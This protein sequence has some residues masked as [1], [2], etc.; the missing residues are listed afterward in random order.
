MMV[1]IL[2]PMLL[3]KRALIAL[4]LSLCLGAGV[5]RAEQGGS[6]Q[7]IV[8]ASDQAIF[9]TDAGLTPVRVELADDPQERAQGL[10][11]RKALTPGHGMLF[12]YE[13]PRES[14]FWMRN[15]LIPLDMIFMDAQG[16]IRHIHRNAR[17]LDEAPIPGALPGDPDPQRLMVLE[18]AAGEANR[19]GLATGQP[20]AHPA[21][22][23]KHAALG[24]N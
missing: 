1:T 4:G 3:N 22:D 18:V 6:A 7:G 9:L 23:K 5:A 10:M 19:L 15:T 11:F 21:L 24:C 8:C 2:S 16:V 14:S 12:I 13:T 20:M 17:P